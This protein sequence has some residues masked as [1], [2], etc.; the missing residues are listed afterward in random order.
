MASPASVVGREPCAVARNRCARSGRF[1]VER[2][3]QAARGAAWALGFAIADVGRKELRPRMTTRNLE[4]ILGATARDVRRS[5]D[6]SPRGGAIRTQVAVLRS[7]IDQIHRRDPS[8]AQVIF[9][10]DQAKEELLRLM[11]EMKTRAPA[12]CGR[13]FTG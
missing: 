10:R 12:A 13:A 5:L 4:R 6:A 3:V 8:D 11:R 2:I 9:L 7:V 1:E